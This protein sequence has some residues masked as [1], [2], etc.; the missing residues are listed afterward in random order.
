MIELAP[1]SEVG[2]SYEEAVLYCAFLEYNGHKDWRLPADSE[3]VQ[4]NLYS[5]YLN[6]IASGM[7]CVV[8]VRDV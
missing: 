2:M 7:W 4:Y 8:P 6:D 1:Q 5:W 3:G